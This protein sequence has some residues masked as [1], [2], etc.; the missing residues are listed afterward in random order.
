MGPLGF[1][2]VTLVLSSSLQSPAASPPPISHREYL[3]TIIRA[4]SQAH[5]SLTAINAE[6][7]DDIFGR[8]TAVK[9][10]KIEMEMSA[11]TLAPLAKMTDNESRAAAGAAYVSGF[12]MMVKSLEG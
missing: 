4:L 2:L 11:Q 8:M 7:A 3:E 10:A 12:S 6:K 9:N 5:N 1:A